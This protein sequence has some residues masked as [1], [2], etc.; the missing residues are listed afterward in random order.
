MAASGRTFALLA[1]LFLVVG[2]PLVYGVWE[3]INELLMGHVER[4]ALLIALVLLVA[5]VALLRILSVLL[6]RLDRDAH[7]PPPSRGDD[8]PR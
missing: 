3:E 4:H 8:G 7:H 2:A 6:H 1:T 5:F